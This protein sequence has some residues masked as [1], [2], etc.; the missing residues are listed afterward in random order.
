MKPLTSMCKPHKHVARPPVARTAST[1]QDRC[2]MH[3][4]P[5]YRR[6]GTWGLASA[7]A[8]LTL[9][10]RAQCKSILGYNTRPN[11]LSTKAHPLPSITFPRRDPVHLQLGDLLGPAWRPYFQWRE[12][13]M[14]VVWVITLLI[15]KE[16]GKRSKCAG[17]P[18]PTPV[19]V[20]LRHGLAA[21]HAGGRQVRWLPRPYARSCD[22]SAWAGCSP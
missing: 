20:T 7:R 9:S 19:A 1:H 15:M 18:N 11:P 14:G 2:A 10:S 13:V 22:P 3:D 4:P 12:F 5:M 16:I 17:C 21:C 6:I 8:S